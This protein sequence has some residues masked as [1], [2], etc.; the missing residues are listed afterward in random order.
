MTAGRL[1]GPS[2]PLQGHTRSALRAWRLAYF[3]P[4]HTLEPGA[5]KRLRHDSSGRARRARLSSW[6][7][8]PSAGLSLETTQA[9]WMHFRKRN[10]PL[11]D[12][13]FRQ[14]WAEARGLRG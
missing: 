1:G 4:G 13:L 9:V 14:K 7:P 2:G 10:S 11:Q 5:L 6:R 12:R 8:P 3:D